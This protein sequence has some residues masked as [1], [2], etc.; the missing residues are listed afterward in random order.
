[1]LAA[2]SPLSPVVRNFRDR[3]N[4]A[5]VGVEMIR[6]MGESN[7]DSGCWVT[8]VLLRN[9]VCKQDPKGVT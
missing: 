2:S 7:E 1:M 5:S 3:T 4:N 8:F 9:T 6:A